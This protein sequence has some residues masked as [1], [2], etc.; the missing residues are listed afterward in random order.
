M[1]TGVEIGPES[2]IN[3]RFRLIRSLGQGGMGEVFLA[4]D[5]SNPGQEVALKVLRTEAVGE[6]VDGLRDEFRSMT[7]LRHPNLLTVHDFGTIDGTGI[8]FL[9][10]E[11]VTGGSL[12]DASLPLEPEVVVEVLAQL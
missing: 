12:G 7:R 11:H 4:E 8:P 1:V 5:L 3:G 10:M 9:T 6:D 2:T